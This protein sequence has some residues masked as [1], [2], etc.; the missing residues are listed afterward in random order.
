MISNICKLDI[1]ELSS[2]EVK[3]KMRY[4]DLPEEEEW[5]VPILNEMIFARDNHIEMEGLN[6]KDINDII[7]YVC[8]A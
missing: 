4:R 3:M 5:R 6:R 8:T 7:N 1:A 2:Q